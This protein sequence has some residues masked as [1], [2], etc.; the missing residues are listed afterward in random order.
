MLTD[1]YG[2]PL[3][4][5]SQ[6]ARDAYV[7]GQIAFL[8]GLPGVE[9]AFDRALAADPDFAL[10][11]AAK[12]RNLHA[13]GRVAEARALI[14]QAMQAGQG[15]EGQA[16]SYLEIFNHTIHGRVRE[17]YTLVR[18]HLMDY[19]RDA[20]VAQTC[21]G[22]FSLIGFSGQPGREAENLA[23]AEM[24]APAYGGD[25]WF[26]S[27]L[28][29][30]QMEAGQLAPAEKSIEAS[31]ALRP[32][33][34]HGAHIRAHLYYEQGR[35]QDGLSFLGEWMRGYD[36]DGLMHCHNSWHCALWSLAVGDVDAMW[37]II[38]A[39]LLPEQSQ[40]PPL[41]IFTDLTA[42]YHRAALAG[43]DIPGT[44]WQAV[45][46][47]ASQTFPNPA[48]GFAD[49]HAAL[50][51]AMAGQE[52]PLLRI[53]EGAKGP[54]ADQVAPCARAFRAIAAQDWAGAEA[55][56]VP[57]MAG[58]E[59]L[60]GSRAQRDLLEYTLLHALIRQGKADEARRLLIMR[61]PLTD[62][63]GAVQG[64]AA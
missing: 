29:F 20:F 32:R 36:R 63:A 16:R 57:V 31:L 41:N 46:E 59:R 35:T 52:A 60:G 40:S 55:A 27:Q 54:A 45:S 3:H 61:R 38:D 33:S 43:V 44:R 28:A 56:L 51:H 11:F 18:A 58:H 23:V 62:S 30:A 42:L 22:V 25:S 2:N 17:G 14:S 13:Y 1:Y 5:T 34:A 64:L 47:Y 12:A 7:E 26:L 10:A 37:R 24:L 6:T 39:D 8:E 9:D 49:I 15:I 19:P 4:T 53:I 50:A 21:L 48:L